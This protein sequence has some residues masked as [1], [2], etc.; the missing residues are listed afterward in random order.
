MSDEKSRVTLP[1]GPLNL[2][3]W[4]HAPAGTPRALIAALHGGSYDSTYFDYRARD[5]ASF[6]AV[7]TALGFAVVAIDR[8]GYGATT[9]A[10][11][12]FSPFERQTELL[13]DALRAA[14]DAYAVGSGFFLV[15]HSIGGMLALCIA[16]LT[17]RVPV[18]GLEASGMGVMYQPGFREARAAVPVTAGASALS[19][20][21]RVAFMY[22]PPET[23]DEQVVDED[24]LHATAAPSSEL[25]D[26][27]T[28][29]ERFARI[30]PSIHV[31]VR[32][33]IAEYDRLWVSSPEALE[34]IVDVLPNA[35]VVEVRMLPQ[36]GHSTHGHRVARAHYLD[37]LSFAEQ[38]IVRAEIGG[39]G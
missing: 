22:G 28:W 13:S 31:P 30:G 21:A 36:A 5:D 7:A 17:D 29:P 26:A 14:W 20:E 6:A 27:F 38:C 15:G 1:A 4:Y 32:V 16:A 24:L 19:A 39:N 34:A 2:S 33:N 23:Y 35:P 3:A 25:A 12:Q 18:I 10:D 11:P 8:P 9:G 37:M